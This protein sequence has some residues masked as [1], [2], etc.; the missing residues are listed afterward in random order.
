[1]RRFFNRL[2]VFWR[3]LFLFV[4]LVFPMYL[5]SVY[6]TIQGQNSVRS[7][8]LKLSESKGNYYISQLETQLYNVMRLQLNILNDDDVQELQRSDIQL[9]PS[10]CI[11]KLNNIRNKLIETASMNMY[12]KEITVYLPLVGRKVTTQS[13]L[14]L[15]ME[16]YLKFFK[17]SSIHDL[18]FSFIDNEYYINMTTDFSNQPVHS[19]NEPKLHVV[20]ISIWKES[21]LSEMVE[22]AGEDGSAYF[23]SDGR[24]LDLAVQGSESIKKHIKDKFH[25]I[26]LGSSLCD[27]FSIDKKQYHMFLNSSSFLHSML[28]IV[29]P[30]NVYVKPL[31]V[32]NAWIW[33]LT[34]LTLILVA[35]FSIWMKSI[36]VHPLEKLI[37][38][39]KHA[40]DDT[41]NIRVVYRKNDEFGDVYRQFNYLIDRLKQLIADVY[42]KE[43]MLKD[44][45]YKQ[46]QYQ[47][48]PHFLYNS[49][50]VT[51]GL[52]ALGENDGALKLT[53]HLSSYYQYITKGQ[54]G[55]IE[56]IREVQHAKDYCEVQNIRF[57]GRIISQFEEIPESMAGFLVPR[58]I[59][60][61]I[62]ENA[63]KHGLK[64]KLRDGR[65]KVSFTE[66]SSYIKVIVE[67]NGDELTDQA[68]SSLRHHIGDIKGDQFGTGMKNV[69][70]RLQIKFK[71]DS[72]I[73]LDR[74]DMGG[75]KVTLLIYRGR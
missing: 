53:K 55:E 44:A 43:L 70:N 21:I 5:F 72:G 62:I 39:L 18:P 9:Q 22:I 35:L 19:M 49:L 71:K 54:A 68:L 33:T 29:V 20:S 10:E 14:P 48:N 24:G 27:Q 45:E 57:Q 37:T 30:D 69:H 63:Y 2:S 11:Y 52:I 7:E 64:N 36:I 12:I 32:F 34:A 51:S 67:D 17:H 66:D 56:L 47:I 26:S 1:M 73:I 8:L 58:L 50:L 60:Q 61:P 3:V 4:V 42:K 28:A 46:L 74:S 16:E 13:I 65:L 75:L 6:I 25:S 41:N 31:R 38:A 15:D 59:L 23:I 40:E